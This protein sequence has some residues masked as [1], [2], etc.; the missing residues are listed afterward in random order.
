[1]T[2]N[3]L[4]A[5]FVIPPGWTRIS[6]SDKTDPMFEFYIDTIFDDKNNFIL[7]D[8][9][10]LAFIKVCQCNV[11]FQLWGETPKQN[12]FI[13]MFELQNDCGE[14]WQID[15]GSLDREDQ[16]YNEWKFVNINKLNI[17]KVVTN[18]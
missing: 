4:T 11:I 15:D 12:I 2:R 6:I 1:M 7:Y 16:L 8:Q 13:Y 17:D 14:E 3:S 10:L 18:S 9:G 5:E